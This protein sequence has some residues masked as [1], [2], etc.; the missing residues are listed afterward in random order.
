MSQPPYQPYQG[1]D[2]SQQ[3]QAPTPYGPAQPGY[4]QAQPAYGQPAQPEQQHQPAYGQ[5][6]PQAAPTPYATPGQPYGAPYPA[7]GQQYGSPYGG[8]AGYGQYAPAGPQPMT[9]R[10]I[11]AYVFS[12]IAVFFL[13]IVF[14]VLAI[15]FSALAVKQNEKTAKVALGVA[16]A[17]TALG[18][19]LGA[20]SAVHTLSQLS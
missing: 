11:L 1:G 7:Q 3:P 18:F 13:P 20:L 12:P 8:P 10:T 14:G 5:M 15:V 2:A 4:G 16:I 6:A 19:G 17:C 9:W